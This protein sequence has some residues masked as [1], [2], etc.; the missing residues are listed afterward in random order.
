MEF[1]SISE[2]ARFGMSYEKARLEAASQNIA[3][4]NVAYSSESE[5]QKAA[6]SITQKFFLM[7]LGVDSN[8]QSSRI[9][10]EA[11]VKMVHDPRHPLAD[12]AGNVFYPD[13]DPVKEMATLVSATRA[14]EANVR[15]YNTN[16]D[17]NAAALSIGGKR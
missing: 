16:G 7:S 14:Y 2:A 6:D 8:N 9:V 12:K 13:I 15:A 10:S 5:A 17:L 4:A 3:I 1:S 11:K